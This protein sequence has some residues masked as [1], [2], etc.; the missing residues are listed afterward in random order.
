VGP[1]LT[2]EL[3]KLARRIVRANRVGTDPLDLQLA[4]A[5]RQRMDLSEAQNKALNRR[6]N[7]LRTMIDPYTGQLV[8]ERG[9]PVGR[10]PEPTEPWTEAEKYVI[11]R[12]SRDVPVEEERRVRIRYPEAEQYVL[13]K[14]RRGEPWDPESVWA[15]LTEETGA[16]AAQPVEVPAPAA[17]PAPIQAA[18]G[19]APTATELSMGRMGEKL[20]GLS[21]MSD[22]EL[23]SLKQE[24]IDKT[25]DF[26]HVAISSQKGAEVR[27]TKIPLRFYND[28]AGQ[29]Q[30][31]IDRRFIAS[32]K[33]K[34]E[35]GTRPIEQAPSAPEPP[36]AA[37]EPPREVPKRD[38]RLGR[39]SQEAL[40]ERA[41]RAFTQLEREA[42]RAQRGVQQWV[43]FDP[44]IQAQRS[45]TVI[46]QDAR[47]AMGRAVLAERRLAAVEQEL[48][49]RGLS[50]EA[51]DDLFEKWREEAATRAGLA[52]EQTTVTTPEDMPFF[53]RKSDLELT[54]QN[55]QVA[56]GE[57]LPPQGQEEAAAEARELLRVLDQRLARSTGKRRQAIAQRM[58]ELMPIAEAGEGIT[59][60]EM[61]LRAIAGA[62][63]KAAPDKT[64]EDLFGAQEDA[65]TG[66]Q[67]D[68]MYAPS[69]PLAGH[70]PQMPIGYLL[71]GNLER[72]ADWDPKESISRPQVMNEI[73]KITEAAG[74]RIPIRSGRVKGQRALGFFRVGPEVIRTKNADDI[75]VAAHE[76][77]HA[78][79]K[80]VFG[81]PKGGPWKKPRASKA[82]QAEL[83]Q[84][85][86]D[87]YGKTKPAGGYK[88]EGFAEFWRMW[89]ENDPQ[90]KTKAPAFHQWFETEFFGEF[91]EIKV[92]AE[93]ARAAVGRWQ[94]QGSF[95]RARMSMVDPAA[96]A[97]RARAALQSWERLF[98]MEK[99]M[100]MA[101]P[102]Y[103]MSKEAE[104]RVGRT[105]APSENPFITMSALRTTHAARTK[106]MV[107]RGMID[108]AGNVVGPP[109]NEIRSLV[110]DQQLEF[111]IY[112]WAKRAERLWLD[113]RGPRDPGV[114]LDDA[115]QILEELTTPN[116][117]LAAAK[118][119]D[120]NAGVL[121]YAA[122][123]SPTYRA[124][125]ERVF[126]RDPGSYVPLQRMFE[127]MD[128]LWARS[129]GGIAGSRSPVKRLTGSGRR[130]KDIFPQMIAQTEQTIR[131]AHARMILDQIIK[132]S[133]I[134]GM[135][136]LIEEVPKDML[137]VAS[138]TLAELIDRINAKL[139]ASGAESLL[140]F[141]E[142]AE[143]DF[144]MLNQTLTFFAPA[145]RPK[146]VDPVLPIYQEGVIRWYRVDGRL[147]DTLG[148]LDVYRLPDVGSLPLLEWI[149][150]KPAAAFRAGTTGLRAS[151]GLVWNPLRD[152]QTLWVNSA[153]SANGPKLLWYWARAMADAALNRTVGIDTSPWLDAYLATGGEMAQPLG[154]DI[155]H[156]RLAARRLF[157]GRVVRTL[158]PRNWFEFYRELVQFPEL[159]PRVAEFRAIAEDI[160]WEPGMPM[161]L[162]Q[163]LQLLLAA[164]QVTTDFTA[165]GELSRIINRMVPFHNAAIQG[166][167]ANLRAARRN[168]GKFV[169]RGLQLTAATLL[170]WWLNKDEEWYRE[171]NPR[172]R[173]LHWHFPTEWPEPTLVRIPRAFEVGLIFS[174]L[175]EAFL[176]GWYLQDPKGVE[177]WFGVFRQSIS[178]NVMPVLAGES[179]EQLA[180]WDFYFERP[181][182]PMGE[183]RRPPEEQYNEYTSRAAIRLGELFGVSPRRID[184]AMSGVF[185]YVSADL[186]TLFGLGPAEL[187]REKEAADIPVFGRLFTRGGEL[188]TQP[189]TI[190]ELYTLLDEAQVRQASLK[191]PENQADRQRR[192][193]LTD[194]AQAVTALA[195][196][197]RFTKEAD[198]RREL[199]REALSIAQEAV[200]LDKENA[201]SR[202]RFRR[203]R[204]RTQ[205]QRERVEGMQQ[206]GSRP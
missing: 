141:E 169:W 202:E 73:A 81:W 97:E 75:S 167:R 178:P 106:H 76:V 30:Q 33:A 177:E 152:V 28:A 206:Q 50:N 77:G 116:F 157:Q 137:P 139:F 31:E 49:A 66:V 61:R 175:P 136:H 153:A 7:E 179:A 95:E 79:E 83:A 16:A 78:T 89:L 111:S 71:R 8:E 184:H 128:D 43:R 87:L 188:G 74:R 120:W 56:Q 72:P 130:V 62:E 15:A 150:G 205:T 54:P 44:N 99:L 23:E 41:G 92:A 200:K 93:S 148:S 195:Y 5:D 9:P 190:Q 119:Y 17:P 204:A 39:M 57:L 38:P 187:G 182:V 172:E 13:D 80:V 103:E 84:L 183:L 171:M 180:N 118:V 94:S 162:D 186:L 124:V 6:I 143:I 149:L 45:G 173:F 104:R 158:D 14:I 198:K 132:L 138:A 47:A 127:E 2:P 142:G 52:E 98:S 60:A 123:A 112:L 189:Q 101:Q 90:L 176:D 145:D 25:G 3:E 86:K 193:Q 51:I 19:A 26:I 114:S 65:E 32:G 199:M 194:A 185:G 156:T 85:G 131:A 129:A 69:D 161:T 96:P 181:I 63:Q 108:L 70:T 58:L 146:G 147:Y 100:E 170:L 154:Q 91:P 201:L 109:L 144:D 164:K 122:Q 24:I 10:R 192:L 174:S 1:V 46:N 37:G 55:R 134:E 105:L 22:A 82:M 29:V 196:V 165:A 35:I 12:R 197:R 67:E 166:P 4:A 59:E 68:V 18:A 107:E 155:P 102:L 140:Q 168:P 48:M 117:E 203:L 163:S 27:S 64:Q 133:K 40:V 121:N 151:F 21:K 135:G 53:P 126:E 191:D 34:G 20:R 160:G 42:Q 115:R 36:P 110:Q 159:A 11:E 125:V 113:P 88:R